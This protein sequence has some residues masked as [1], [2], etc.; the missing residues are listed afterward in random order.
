[1]MNLTLTAEQWITL[2]EDGVASARSTAPAYEYGLLT[3]DGQHI[4][5][6]TTTGNLTV[7]RQ[8]K[9]SSPLLKVALHYP[10][11]HASINRPGKTLTLNIESENA[12]LSV[13]SQRSKYKIP[14]FPTDQWPQLPESTFDLINIDAHTL[15]SGLEHVHYAVADR[16]TRYYLNGAAI[17][18]D[19]VVGTD[20]HRLAAYWIESGP[21]D[22]ILPSAS[23]KH[24]ILG[25]KQKDS[26]FYIRQNRIKVESPTLTVETSLIEGKFPNWKGLLSHDERISIEVNRATILESIRRIHTISTMAT[27]EKKDVANITLASDSES[28]AIGIFGNDKETVEWIPA[29]VNQEIRATIRATYLVDLIEHC[30]GETIKLDIPTDPLK[31]TLANDPEHPQ[32]I[33]LV[34]PVQA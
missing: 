20:A 16:D 7:T 14:T 26:L 29:S 33:Y 31:Y 3:S 8:I 5:F 22:I 32:N 4:T 28:Q 25:L 15:A 6:T 9:T 27:G 24:V 30:D 23:I 2:L 18:G 1:M 21:T 11:L 10:S 34:M 19:Y 17:D 12:T 13:E